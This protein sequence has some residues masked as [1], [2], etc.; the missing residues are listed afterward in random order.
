MTEVAIVD[1]T[2]GAWDEDIVADDWPAVSTESPLETTP[3]FDLQS[4]RKQIADEL[5]KSFKVARWDDPDVYMELRVIEPS[6]LSKALV[7]REKQKKN[8]DDWVAWAY[9]DVLAPAVTAV[10][11]IVDGDEETRYSLRQG[12]PSGT[13]TKIDHDLAVALGLDPTAPGNGQAATFRKM[14]FGEADVLEFA[15]RVFRWSSITNDEVD[16]TF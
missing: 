2:E 11:A 15:A 8:L 3:L 4:R 13:P 14:F 1:G 6:D 5:V 16:E 10:Y 7:K 9:C 12:D